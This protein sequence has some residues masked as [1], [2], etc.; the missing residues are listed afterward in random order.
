MPKQVLNTRTSIKSCALVKITDGQVG[1][2]ILA[3]GPNL[4]HDPGFEHPWTRRS[5][6]LIIYT[7]GVFC[8]CDNSLLVLNRN[9]GIFM[10]LDRYLMNNSHI[11]HLTV[12]VFSFL[13][14]L[15][16][17]INSGQTQP[18]TNKHMETSNIRILIV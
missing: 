7:K 9:F 15:F 4:A 11:F 17:S 1:H 13:V 18:Q 5:R 6:K 3:S 14:L 2:S 10:S 16:F 8:H 12:H